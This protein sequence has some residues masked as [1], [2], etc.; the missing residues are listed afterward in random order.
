M[1]KELSK[2]HTE[3]RPDYLLKAVALRVHWLLQPRVLED[4]AHARAL[5]GPPAEH[6]TQQ[7]LQRCKKHTHMDKIIYRYERVQYSK[8]RQVK[9]QI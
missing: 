2:K 3:S 8:R 7:V 6:S 1:S 4:L 5:I 9:L